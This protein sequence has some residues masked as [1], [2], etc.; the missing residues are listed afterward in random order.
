MSIVLHKEPWHIVPKE[1]IERAVNECPDGWGAFIVDVEHGRMWRHVVDV[2]YKEKNHVAEIMKIQQ[3]YKNN[4]VVFTFT[5]ITTPRERGLQ[6]VQPLLTYQDD[7]VTVASSFIGVVPNHFW[8]SNG[9]THPFHTMNQQLLR[10]LFKLMA[11]KYPGK[12]LINN[13]DLV[14]VIAPM[15]NGISCLIL[16]D[17]FGSINFVGKESLRSKEYSW[18]WASQEMGEEAKSEIEKPELPEVKIHRKPQQE[19]DLFDADEDHKKMQG[20]IEAHTL[21][22]EAS[23]V[24][25]MPMPGAPPFSKETAKRLHMKY[26]SND[27]KN[28]PDPDLVNRMTESNPSFAELTGMKSITDITNWRSSAIADLIENEDKQVIVSLIQDMQFWMWMNMA[29]KENGHQSGTAQPRKSPF[30]DYER[31]KEAA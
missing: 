3:G 8:S 16:M 28:I 26:V 7:E 27:G 21:P 2:N 6:S 24:T 19:E 25:V 29:S 15:L 10:D 17:S 13:P 9:T 31:K 22:K 5:N 20:F 4:Q 12:A 1:V 18:G 14:K 30:P 11:F 23:K